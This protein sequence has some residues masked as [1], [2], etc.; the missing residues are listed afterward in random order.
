M[1]VLMLGSLTV[2]SVLAF[3]M[4]RRNNDPACCTVSVSATPCEA[5]GLLK[6]DRSNWLNYNNKAFLVVV[7]ISF[8]ESCCHYYRYSFRKALFR[9]VRRQ[10]NTL[11]LGVSSKRMDCSSQPCLY[12]F[13][14]T[15]LIFHDQVCISRSLI[16]LF[17]LQRSTTSSLSSSFLC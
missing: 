6:I 1:D 11:R 2:H 4:F 14:R 17:W 7:I 15:P 16:S 13:H 12:V 3:L 8:R 10:L 9:P 5:G